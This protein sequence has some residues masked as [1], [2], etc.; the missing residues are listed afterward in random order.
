MS[1][2]KTITT[3]L[4]VAGLF[5]A[6]AVWAADSASQTFITEAIQGNLAEISVGQLA[7]QK[8]STDDIKQFGQTLVTDHTKANQKALDVA[9]TLGVTAPTAPSDAQKTMHDKLAGETGTAFD[10]DFVDGMVD[11]HRNTIGK[12]Q[13]AANN[14]KD[15]AGQYAAETLPTVQMHLK[16]VQAIASNTK[17]NV[18]DNNSTSVNSETAP[19]AGANSFTEGQA[20]ARIEKA[21]YAGVNG[22]KQ[23]EQGIWRGTASK[24]GQSTP[25]ALDFKGN[26]VGK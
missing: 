14:D 17:M 3:V 1:K 11:G 20:K 16:M 21:G 12:Y 6:P 4:A 9:K 22:L 10:H 24:N 13:E 19:L 8:G 18:T 26:V 25:V 23:D 2:R 5:A 7:Q 15:A